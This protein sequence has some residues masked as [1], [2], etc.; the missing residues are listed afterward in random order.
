MKSR[1]RLLLLTIPLGVIA[2]AGC[3]NPVL[4]GGGVAIQAA[5]GPASGVCLNCH[6]S[7]YGFTGVAAV[8]VTAYSSSGHANGLR[9][10]NSDGSYAISQWP[11]Q[12]SGS[13]SK[14]HTQDGFVSWTTYGAA[15]VAISGTTGPTSI[16]NASLTAS[17]GNHVS[18]YACH[19]P[20]VN[21]NMDPRIQVPVALG[22]G[23]SGLGATATTV[24]TNIFSGGQG[25][26]CVNC[27]Q[28]RTDN[29]KRNGLMTAFGA[30][31]GLNITINGSKIYYTNTTGYAPVLGGNPHHGLQSDLLMGVDS[32]A[33][34][35]VT[36]LGY[37]PSASFTNSHY[38]SAFKTTSTGAND[39]CVTC[40]VTSNT[41]YT[42]GQ[43]T[44]HGMYLTSTATGDNVA[45]CAVCH[46]PSGTATHKVNDGG[47]SFKTFVT[48]STLLTDIDS[49]KQTLLGFFG[50]PAYFFSVSSGDGKSAGTPYVFAGFGVGATGAVQGVIT[51]NGGV[52]AASGGAG[53]TTTLLPGQ[54]IPGATWVWKKDWEFASG[55]FMTV[56]EYQALWNFKIFAE[57][58]SN[59]I[60]NPRYAA[61]L[62]YDAIT[63]INS[64]TG[65]GGVRAGPL[66]SDLP[67]P[68]NW[69]SR[70]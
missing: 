22:S 30:G 65:V 39:S 45:V 68:T 8:N 28:D 54:Y 60:H 52:P 55:V 29:S 44:S 49:A 43:V 62:L 21:W 47:T 50:N 41:Q 36:T 37:T 69:G 42:T 1:W 33:V 7:N 20:H 31:T 25:N 24:S 18:C 51:V 16:A 46:N 32:A 35:T 14:C 64:D 59:G 4:G 3:P 70:P 38:G 10:M 40:H 2:L 13:C 57:D 58:R 11:D 15:P 27:H 23:M 9:V 61:E 63:L 53:G 56:K 34:N 12:S 66:A 48:G 17:S 26:L 19:N 6:T 5:S 67:L